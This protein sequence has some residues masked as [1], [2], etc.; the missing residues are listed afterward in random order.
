M[1]ICFSDAASVSP[2]SWRQHLLPAFLRFW[3][4]W[5]SCTVDTISY[6]FYACAR[7]F[8]IH[9]SNQWMLRL[10]TQKENCEQDNKMHLP[11]KR[12]VKKNLPAHYYFLS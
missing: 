8:I 3:H 7:E 10:Y 5:S 2:L 11:Q 4:L 1:H 12:P 9:P 6:N